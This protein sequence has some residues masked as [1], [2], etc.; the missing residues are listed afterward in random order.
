MKRI[1]IV[2]IVLLAFGAFI[3]AGDSVAQKKWITYSCGFW[4]KWEE[5]SSIAVSGDDLWFGTDANGLFH[6]DTRIMDYQQITTD[7]SLAHNSILDL[8]FGPDNALWISSV[9]GLQK[10]H[11]DTWTTYT[12]EHL[13]PNITKMGTLAIDP[14]GIVWIGTTYKINHVLYGEVSRFDGEICTTY[15]TDDGLASGGVRSLSIAG[16]GTVWAGGYEGL[17]RFDGEKWTIYFSADGVTPD[18]LESVVVAA[19]GT[20]WAGGSN[21]IFHIDGE[22]C[23][24]YG[25]N[26]LVLAVDYNNDLWVGYWSEILRFDGTKWI[27]YYATDLSGDYQRYIEMINNHEDSYFE[28]LG[29]EC[30]TLA[31][32]YDGVVWAGTQDGLSRYGWPLIDLVEDTALPAV[33][34]ICRAY[35][36][37]FNSAA[38]IEY[39]LP[40]EG[41]TRLAVYSITGQKVATLVDDYRRAG[42]HAVRFDGSHLASGMYFYR[43]TAGGFEK[44][45]RMALVK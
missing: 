25:Y 42:T 24:K 39:V 6:V 43:L 12:I 41:Y 10:Y 23:Q 21:G 44:M 34:T 13:F 35:P 14:D 20:V 9:G 17:S 8:E 30:F 27:T 26:A 3:K 28:G 7:D 36:N 5:I 16:D 31:V 29:Y 40:V 38:T 2:M 18:Q 37:P 22:T 32:G 4:H 1:L 45:G 15:T 33:I 19:D 11:H